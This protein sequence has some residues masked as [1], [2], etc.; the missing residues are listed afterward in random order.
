MIGDRRAALKLAS[1]SES[2]ARDSERHAV[3][4]RHLRAGPE[5]RLADDIA[6]A[7]RHPIG[8]GRYASDH[9]DQALI[10]ARARFYICASEGMIEGV[11]QDLKTRGVPAFEIFSERF[12]SPMDVAADVSNLS[13]REVTFARSGRKLTWKPQEGSLLQMAEASGISLPSGCRVGQCESCATRVLQ[14]SV[15]HLSKV[16]LAEDNICLTCIG[17]PVSDLVL[18]A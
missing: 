13:P 8:Q 6:H 1:G 3:P 12:V 9:V 16:D 14:G 18:D 17:V 4:P 5:P 10:D 2:P 11:T 15:M 7:G